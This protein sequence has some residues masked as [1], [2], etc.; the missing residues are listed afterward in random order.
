[1]AEWSVKRLT[2]IDVVLTD[3]VFAEPAFWYH[4]EKRRCES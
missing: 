1:M 3:A 2:N 4:G